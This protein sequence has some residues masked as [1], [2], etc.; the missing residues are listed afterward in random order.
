VGAVEGVDFHQFYEREGAAVRARIE[1][2]LP[3]GWS[4]EDKRVLDFGCGSARVLRQFADEAQTAEL[5]G[6]DVH[7]PSVQWVREHLSPPLHCFQNEPDP[8]LPLADGYL[9]LVW[10][11]SVFTH[12]TDNWSSWLL[13]LHR[14]LRPG[15]T[16]IA[17]F[18]GEG[19]WDA[20]LG[21]PYNE[22]CVGMTVLRHW[23]DG[24]WV[25][26]SEWWL[27]EHW[28]R[29][30]EVLEVSRPERASD[31]TPQVTH[32]YIALRKHGATLDRAALERCAADEPREFAG[33][34]TQIRL[35]RD[36][37]DSLI[38]QQPPPGTRTSAWRRALLASPLRRPAR[39]VARWL[40][41]R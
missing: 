23:Q 10:A 7:G 41:V 20:M 40:R 15:G 9:D 25:F 35:L 16:L 19:V 27:R 32:S 3:S 24:P 37:I 30:F 4:F 34:R 39:A 22:D 26:H 29:L 38:A 28:G 5:W 8:P 17:S 2:L 21:E 11:T 36:E 33:L 13:E 14:V 12:I 6:C 18:L 1:S 31:G